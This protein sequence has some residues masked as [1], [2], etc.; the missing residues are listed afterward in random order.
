MLTID[1][2]IGEG[3]GQVLRSALAL[4]PFVGEPFRIVNI[5]ARRPRPGLRPQHLAAVRA[6]A[7]ISDA[8]VTGAVLDA[9]E[10]TF[11]PG[12]VRAGEYHFAIGTAGSTALVV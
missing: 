2:S 5:R 12:C 9:R 1:G 3:G 8:R 7:E 11:V 10:L 6:A 4:S